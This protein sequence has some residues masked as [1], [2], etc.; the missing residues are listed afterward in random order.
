MQTIQSSNFASFKSSRALG[1]LSSPPRRDLGPQASTATCDDVSLS[2]G[3]ARRKQSSKLWTAAVLGGLAAVS[4]AGC[5][6]NSA[7]A[8]AIAESALP[9]V[10]NTSF[11]YAPVELI[12]TADGEVV[13]NLSIGD[14]VVNPDSGTHYQVLG[15][16]E[17]SWDQRGETICKQ[18]LDLGGEC[19]ADNIATITTP[20]G[21]LIIEQN[22]AN[23]ID[24]YSQDGGHTGVKV[25]AGGIEVQT[26]RG[27]A[28]FANDGSV[29]TR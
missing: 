5:M 15:S 16:E 20:R 22:E 2:A 13:I 25:Q 1:K 12:R 7:L 21:T 29:I 9:Q 8:P 23:S 24:V 28:Y 27:G 6:T 14:R 11:E 18:A 19:E 3:A 10:Q 4:L 17:A 26:F